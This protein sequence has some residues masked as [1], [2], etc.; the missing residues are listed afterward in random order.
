MLNDINW[1]KVAFNKSLQVFINELISILIL[2]YML[3]LISPILT[4][5]ILCTVPI[6]A[7]LILK[8][9]QSIKRKV[10]RKS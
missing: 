10:K 3:F 6:S 7:F 8:I 4:L 2:V 9:S 5:L 1:I